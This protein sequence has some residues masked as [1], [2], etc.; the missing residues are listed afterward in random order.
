MQVLTVTPSD[1]RLTGPASAMQKLGEIA[2]TN[3]V[4]GLCTLVL[5]SEADKQNCFVLLDVPNQ[6]TREDLSKLKPE[7]PVFLLGETERP[8]RSENV[9]SRFSDLCGV[10]SDGRLILTS[11]APSHTG[12]RLS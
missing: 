8:L 1:A 4:M 7:M 9:T 11:F 6:I 5:M 12:M 2:M 3:E 10:V